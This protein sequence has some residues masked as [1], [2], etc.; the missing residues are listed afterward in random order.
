MECFS[1]PLPRQNGGSAP[2]IAVLLGAHSLAEESQLL[3]AL[4]S[5]YQS[6]MTEEDA[7]ASSA[8]G[9]GDKSSLV[10]TYELSR[11]AGMLK[12]V[13]TAATTDDGFEAPRW[14]PI[15]RGEEKV[16]VENGWSFLDPDEAE[17]LSAFDVDSANLEGQY[18]PKWGDSVDVAEIG[19][20]MMLSSLGYDIGPLSR[21]DIVSEADALTND[22]SKG[23]MLAG[24]TDTPGSKTTSNGCDF[25]GA[26]GQADIPAGIFTCAIGGLPLFASTD[27]SPMTGSSGWLT[28]TRPISIDHVVH[29]EPEQ[30][31]LDNR[32][33]VVDARSKCHLGHYF[34]GSDGYCI[35]ASALCFIPLESLDEDIPVGNVP[36]VSRPVSY[37]SVSWDEYEPT[38]ISPS[39]RNLKSM[40]DKSVRYESVAL[41]AG[42]FW[43]VE[44]ALRRLPGVLATETAYAGG[45]T[46]SP[47]YRDVCEGRTGHAEVVKIT[48]DPDILHFDVLFDCFLS[49]HDPTKVRSHGKHAEGTGQYRSSIFCEN[50]EIYQAALSSLGRC[51]E[52]LGKELSTDLRLIQQPT[53]DS[54][55]GEGWCWKA[56]ERHQRHDEN[57]KKT[58]GEEM[59]TLSAREWLKQ[60]GRRRAT[61]AGSAETVPVGMDGHPDDDGMARLMI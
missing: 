61:I 26:A 3:A 2:A 59:T 19:Q 6:V 18:V 22:Q 4:Q 38:T 41:G 25:Q 50:P 10:F 31:A 48:F 45:S 29:I 51:R 49:M 14:V 27:L 52:Q 12:L 9:G 56:E 58:V 24:Q 30:G 15:V 20:Q 33:E 39:I 44:F 23:V 11:A 60:Y 32:V 42:C 21:E 28:F 7:M 34:F 37:R 36:P 57:L 35:N 53:P 54:H 1:T 16:L 43:H 13:S 17:P 8:R 46:L 40:L 47:S 5:T 55:F